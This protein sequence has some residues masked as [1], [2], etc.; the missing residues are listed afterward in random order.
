MGECSSEQVLIPGPMRIVFLG[1]GRLASN[2]APALQRAGHSVVQVFSRTSRSAEQLAQKVG[3]RAVTDV[4]QLVT[5]ADVYVFSV[6]DAVLPSLAEKLSRHLNAQ[7]KDTASAVF[8][9]T[10]GSVPLSVFQSL[11]CHYGVVYPMQT[12]SKERM[13]DFDHL[14]IFI[15]GNDDVSLSVAWQLATS[16]ST[17]VRELPSSARRQLHLAAVFACNFVN[18]C[19]QLSAEILDKHGLSFEVMLPLIDETAAKVHVLPPVQAQTG[20]AVRYDEN[21]L[22]AQQQL[23]ADLPYH[24][25]VYEL[26]SESIHHSKQNYEQK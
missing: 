19:Y 12:F 22:R 11:S 16:V 18:H 7:Q 5:D 8:L 20:P 3:G 4:N 14:P 25:R 2:L 9:H 13:V 17:N 15:E 1:A 23:L 10:A 24:A 6:S 21:V 26:M